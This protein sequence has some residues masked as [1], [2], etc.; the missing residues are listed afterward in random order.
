MGLTGVTGVLPIVLAVDTDPASLDRLADIV[1]LPAVSW[2]PPAPAWYGVLGIML[3]LAS[4]G[5]MALWLQRWANAY[6]AAALAELN[7][8]GQDPQR[9]IHIAQ[10]L[11]RTA[12]AAA[13]RQQVAALSGEGW[14]RWLNQTGN[15]VIF[16]EKSQAVLADHVYGAGQPT[17][18][19][20]AAL[21]ST[22]RAWISRHRLGVAAKPAEAPESQRG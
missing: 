18:Q 10:I 15:G 12:L 22:A 14:V 9:V 2:W 5:V 13:P 20:I 1:T 7:R 16:T 6:R 4:V 19:E 3:V 11:K 8:V 21:V 17:N